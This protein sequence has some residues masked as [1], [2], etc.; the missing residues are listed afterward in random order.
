MTVMPIAIIQARV[1]D[2]YGVPLEAMCSQRRTYN[3]V[4]PRHVAM[5]LSHELVPNASFPMIARAFRRLDHTTAIYA[6]NKI[7]ATIPKD[8]NLASRVETLRA[9]LS[10]ELA[11]LPGD[12]NP[13]IRAKAAR[14]AREV[15]N[16]IY[17]AADADP[18]A[19][20]RR[21]RPK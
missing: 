16:K 3:W 10:Q 11:Q 19:F 8:S 2:T 4:R 9:A 17:T 20:V 18:D 6:I 21:F 13:D 12:Q 15:S 1:A 5:Y 14:L 7:R